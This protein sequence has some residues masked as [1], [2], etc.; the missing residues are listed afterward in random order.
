MTTVYS[1]ALILAVVV[2][3]FGVTIVKYEN[4][5]AF[6]KWRDLL[7]ER[8][9]LRMEW[10]RLQVGQGS[11]GAHDRIERLATERLQMRKLSFERQKTIL[12]E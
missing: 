2:S 7:E 8:D 9:A 10:K 12:Y 11:F 5:A 6:M 4:R 1:A 3:A